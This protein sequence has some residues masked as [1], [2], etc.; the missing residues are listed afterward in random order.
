MTK[1]QPPVDSELVADLRR[2]AAGLTAELRKLADRVERLGAAIEELTPRMPEPEPEPTA[3]AGS[4][5]AG[6][7][8][9]EDAAGGR[10]FRLVVTPIR[11]LALAAVAETSLRSLPEV[12]RVVEITRSDSEAAFELEL[13]P[14]A[15][16][17]SGLRA[18]LPLPFDVASST[19]NEL[20]I[21]LRPVWGPAV[22][23]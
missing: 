21:S 2:E 13:A 16:L 23:S 5:G 20:V 3:T 15:D 18:S 9:G 14:G 6:A 19:E 17:L 8:G 10:A 11:E 12:R 1:R 7:E 4:P 22:S